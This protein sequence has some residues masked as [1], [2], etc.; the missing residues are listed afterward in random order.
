MYTN[1]Q[2]KKAQEPG[3]E[4]VGYHWQQTDPQ[5]TVCIIHGIGEHAGRYDRM[6]AEMNR[7]GFSVLSMDLRGHGK[8]CGKR[9]HCAPRTEVKSDI[10]DLLSYAKQAYPNTPII[11]YGHS[12]GGNLVLDYRKRGTLNHLPAAYII[13]APW[14]ELVR[15]VPGPLYAAVKLLSRIAPKFSI[16]SGV[17]ASDLGHKSS[18]GEYEK[19][20]LVHKKITA[21]CA[22]EGFDIGSA[23]AEGRL[24]DNGG[25]AGKPMLL[26]HGTGDKVCSING[27][28]KI[29]AAENCEYIEWPGLYHEIHNGGAE[30]TGEEVIEKV[31]RWIQALSA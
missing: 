31:I 17:S 21:L 6:A 29:A 10:D 18:V 22:V 16:A 26:M 8:S 20:P 9:G 2:L 1:F 11:L 15:P 14:V 5:Y 19:D 12:M 27:S 30:S 13:S 3:G 7:A 28:K 25:A 4:I 23:M 24:E